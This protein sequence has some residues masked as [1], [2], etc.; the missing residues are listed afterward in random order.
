MVKEEVM[1]KKAK[2]IVGK[3]GN[4]IVFM[5][6]EAKML[7]WGSHTVVKVSVVREGRERWV[8]IEKVGDV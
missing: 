7:G 1:H 2:R 8:K 4:Y 5:T 3:Q 6:P